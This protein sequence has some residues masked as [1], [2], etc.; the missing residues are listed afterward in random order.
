MDV[1]ISSSL[2]TEELAQR[3]AQADSRVELLYQPELLAPARWNGDIAGDPG[4]RR[5]DEGES[6]WQ[7]LLE[8]AEVLFGIPR[9]SADGLVEAVRAGK[10]LRWV[11]GRNAGAGEQLG[12]AAEQARVE[13]ERVIMTT[14]SGIHAGPLAEFALLGM[15]AFAKQL[16]QRMADQRGHHWPAEQAPVGELRGRTLLLVGLGAIGSE[17]AR[18]AKAFGMEVLAVKRDASGQHRHVDELHPAERLRE[19]FGRADAIVSSLPLTEATRGLID[20]ETLGAAKRGAVFVNVGRGGVVDEGALI[21]RLRDGTLGGAALDVF[22]QE[23]LP[24][25]SPLW[26]LDNVI[27]SPHASALVEAEEERGV[28]LFCDNLRRFLDGQPLRNQLDLEVLY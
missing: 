8:R 3:I 26:D 23:P 17:T 5:D 6:R 19:L 10:R 4:F 27:V 14:T 24:S 9:G 2:W 12:Q 22:E 16:P 13:L 11:Q 25:G 28:D 20:A 18:L 7:E 15:L 1:L 21:E